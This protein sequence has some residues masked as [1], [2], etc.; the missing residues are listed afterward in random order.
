MRLLLRV[1]LLLMSLFTSHQ[2]W[3]HAKP[4]AQS[5]LANAQLNEAKEIRLQFSETLEPAFCTVQLFNE[6]GVKINLAKPTIDDKTLFVALPALI[7]GR[8]SVKW[9]VVS[10][11]GHRTKSSYHF[12]I[13]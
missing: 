8:Y 12:F 7:K 5:P 4:Q 2:V 6:N 11:D 10:V 13:K 3:A 9:S 1:S